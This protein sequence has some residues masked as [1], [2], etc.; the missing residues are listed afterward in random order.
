M[1][2]SK[3]SCLTIKASRSVDDMIRQT[4]G[5][6]GY[7]VSSQSLGVCAFVRVFV[8]LHPC[9]CESVCVFDKSSAASTRSGNIT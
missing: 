7:S 3:L 1:H 8:C 6:R 4:W 9:V 2:T 5:S